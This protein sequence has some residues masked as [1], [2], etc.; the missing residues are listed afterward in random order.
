[1]HKARKRR[2]SLVYAN[3]VNFDR[4]EACLDSSKQEQLLGLQFPWQLQPT[5]EPSPSSMVFASDIMTFVNTNEAGGYSTVE[6]FGSTSNLTKLSSA[7][8]ISFAKDV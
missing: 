4:L 8:A 2:F 7:L 6:S 5:I 1:V 3:A